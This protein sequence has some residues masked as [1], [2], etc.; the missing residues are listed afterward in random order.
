[1]NRYLTWHHGFWQ[2]RGI[3]GA[4]PYPLVGTMYTVLKKV[5]LSIVCYTV[6]V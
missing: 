2:R 5:R 4:R 3:P 6:K 1:M